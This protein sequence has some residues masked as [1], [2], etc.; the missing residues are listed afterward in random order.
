MKSKFNIRIH[1]ITLHINKTKIVI[2]FSNLK[3]NLIQSQ[4]I[5]KLT[6]FFNPN[7]IIKITN[8]KIL[9]TKK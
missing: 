2:I 3:I 9:I 6:P 5:L 7:M 1:S 4:N 8:F